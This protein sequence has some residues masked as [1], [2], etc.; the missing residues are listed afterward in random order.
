MAFIAT[1]F[2][3]IAFAGAMIL[4][5]SREEKPAHAACA[6]SHLSPQKVRG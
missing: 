6:E 1:F 4:A 5:R 2:A 3:F